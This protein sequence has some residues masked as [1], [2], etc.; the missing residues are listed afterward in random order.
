MSIIASWLVNPE[1][2]AESIIARSPNMKNYSELEGENVLLFI[3]R[4]D[5]KR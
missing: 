1:V 2:N 5:S 4:H 3:L